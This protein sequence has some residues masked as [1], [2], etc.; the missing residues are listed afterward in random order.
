M[1]DEYS[2]SKTTPKKGSFKNSKILFQLNVVNEYYP[3]MP[4]IHNAYLQHQ[5]IALAER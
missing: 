2:T 5:N 4:M 1:D 3:V